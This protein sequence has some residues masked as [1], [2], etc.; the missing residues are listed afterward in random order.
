MLTSTRVPD[1]CDCRHVCF[2]LLPSPISYLFFAHRI[3][4]LK[5]GQIVEQGSHRDLIARDGVFASMWA[6]QISSSDDPAISIGNSSTKKEVSGYS[7]NPETGGDPADAPQVDTGDLPTTGSEF[8]TTDVP[9]DPNAA[10][11]FPSYAAVANPEV[12]TEVH[13]QASTSVAFP[14]A[15]EPD[16]TSD[17]DPSG[18]SPPTVTFDA[19]VSTPPS[20]AP[21][22]DGEPKKKGM[23]AQNFQRLAR[24]IS[25]TTKR[26]GSLSSIPGFGPKKESSKDD[27]GS[28]KGEPSTRSADSPAG[29]VIGAGDKDKKPKKEKKRKS[30][31]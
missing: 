15:G 9:V 7:V 26:S 23:S 19:G 28:L 10:V 2:L 14:G 12:P 6:D 30:L 31:I 25:L 3:L 20:S 29:S 18:P 8:G 5:D 24:R 16:V 1:N 13:G 11:S 21:D 22:V 17:R 4:V 27:T